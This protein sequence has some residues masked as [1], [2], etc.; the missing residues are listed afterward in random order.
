V[1]LLLSAPGIKPQIVETLTST[2]QIAP[3]VL[4]ALGIDPKR[5]RLKT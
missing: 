3:T 5:L 4:S 2:T 1:L